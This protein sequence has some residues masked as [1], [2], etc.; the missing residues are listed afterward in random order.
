MSITSKSRDTPPT[1]VRLPAS[2]RET[3]R[4]HAFR[5]LCAH[6]HRAQLISD[7]VAMETSTL[8]VSCHDRRDDSCPS[9]FGHPGTVKRLDWHA[10][11]QRYRMSPVDS[12]GR[13]HSYWSYSDTPMS[14]NDM[15]LMAKDDPLASRI[16]NRTPPDPILYNASM[17]VRVAVQPATMARIMNDM[18]A[19]YAQAVVRRCSGGRLSSPLCRWIVSFL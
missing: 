13:G 10:P 14:T 19:A 2:L 17:L 11:T 15:R 18:Y 6:F 5:S 16:S 12:N 9:R 4:E 1:D 7:R 3:F 8:Y